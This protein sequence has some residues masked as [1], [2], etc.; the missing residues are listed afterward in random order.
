MLI[1]DGCSAFELLIKR[2]RFISETAP[3]SSPE[4]ARELL[5]NKKLEHPDAAHVVHAFIA[6]DDRQYM[7]MSDDG[8]PSGTSGKPTL[9]VLKGRGIT[10]I[11]LTTVRYFGG[12]KLGTGGLV[13]A[14]SEAAAGALD[15]LSTRELIKYR[16]FQITAD[17]HFYQ[18]LKTIIL[19]HECRI[20][21]ENFG[22]GVDLGGFVPVD[23]AD[24]L[25]AAVIDASSGRAEI[26][27]SSDISQ[28]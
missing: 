22:I 10:N 9:E 6:G 26:I 25:E 19:E 4:A 14:Y 3:V 24:A 28:V 1:P 16:E 7:G 13:K 23:K 12:T 11:L 15:K 5:K 27:I 20:E 8:E 17:Y 18:P 2:S 21:D